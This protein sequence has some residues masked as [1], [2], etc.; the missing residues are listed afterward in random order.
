MQIQATDAGVP[1]GSLTYFLLN[2]TNRHQHNPKELSLS[3][4]DGNAFLNA[5]WGPRGSGPNA[6]C[7]MLALSTSSRISLH[8]VSSF[9]MSW[10][11]VSVFSEKLFGFFQGRDFLLKPKATNGSLNDAVKSSRAG[12]AKKRKRG[13][14]GDKE[15][16]PSEEVSSQNS[17]AEYARRCSLLATLTIAWSPFVRVKKSM[18]LTSLIAFGGRKVCTVWSYRY[19]EFEAA[20]AVREGNDL[21]SQAPLAWMDTEKYGWVTTSTWQQMHYDQSTPLTHMELALGTAD[22]NVLLTTIPLAEASASAVELGIDRVIRMPHSQPVFGLCLGC[23]STFSNSPSNDLIAA[24]GSTISVWNVKKKRPQLTRKWKAHEGN[25]TSLDLDYFG[26]SVYSSGVDGAVNVWDKGTGTRSLSNFD[27]FRNDGDAPT[28][29]RRSLPSNGAS[30]SKNG[31]YPVFGIAVS[32]SSAQVACVYVIPPA[33]RPNRKSQADVSYTR[34]SSSLEFLPSPWMQHPMEEFVSKTCSI[35]EES[36]SASAFTDVVWF[37]H[38]DNAAI[39]SLH[40]STEDIVPALLSK[41]TGVRGEDGEP[42]GVLSRKPVYFDL[43]QV[44]KERHSHLNDLFLPI[45]LQA[46]YLILVS[47][48]PIQAFSLEHNQAFERVR[49]QLLAYWAQRC[50]TD[51]VNASRRSDSES[52]S[53]FLADSPSDRVSALLMADF[54]SVQTPATAAVVKLVSEIYSQLASE[55]TVTK[56]TDY[57]QK[58]TQRASTDEAQPGAPTVSPPIPPPRET[59]Y[60]CDKA[61]PFGEF[62]LQCESN[63]AQDR[64][65]LSFRVISSMD[66]WKCMGCGALAGE[67]DLTRVT[68]PFYLPGNGDETSCDSASAVPSASSSNIRCRLCGNYCSFFKY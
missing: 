6:S 66:S 33:A 45:F 26:T 39:S 63:H 68:A 67:L 8:F 25:I 15:A 50:L 40:D 11:E 27:V 61:V 21:L 2:D 38:E 12:V 28:S 13:Q 48:D 16:A 22:G 1:S 56:W 20:G 29:Q 46:A 60:I 5:T 17:M 53:T 7:A 31:R 9:H 51:L 10:K 58:R 41:L 55:E 52:L 57:L 43:C 47:I 3:K 35:L 64:C 30:N 62:D 42:I 34:V 36:R 18:K 32:P 65:F 37:C 59:C 49:R 24:A 54:L 4:N 44:L 14:S 23:R 19:C